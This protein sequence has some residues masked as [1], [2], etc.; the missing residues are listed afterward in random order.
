MAEDMYF[1]DLPSLVEV[2][3]TPADGVG[4]GWIAVE[5]ETEE[6]N[7][8]GLAAGS[9]SGAPMLALNLNLHGTYTLY[10]ALSTQTALKVWIEGE[11]GYREFVTE[12]GGNALQECQLHVVTLNGER[13]CIEPKNDCLPKPAFLGYIRAVPAA[14]P[15]PSARNMV[16]TN[17]GWS[18]VALDGIHEARDVWR[19][20]TPLRDSDFRLMLWGPAGAD[21]TGCHRTKVG[22]IAPRDT[23][24][25]FRVCDY[26]HAENLQAF[27]KTG[28][29][30]LAEAVAAARANEV[31][32]H[33]YIRPE[34]FFAPFPFNVFASQ[35]MLDHPEL[36]CRDE[37]DDEIMRLSYGYPEVQEHMLAYF[38]ELLEYRPDG[39]CFAFNRGL[40]MLICEA[41]VLAEFERLHGRAARLPEEADSDEMIAA[42]TS[43]LTQFLERVR[44][45]LAQRG[46]AFSCIVL[47]DE[48]HNRL[49]GLDLEALVERGVFESIMV[50]SGGMHAASGTGELTPYWRRLRDSGKVKIYPNGWNGTYDYA[51]QARYLKEN[52]FDQGFA[53]GFFW[54]TENFTT[55]PWNWLPLRRGGSP[56]HLQAL[57]NGS[58]ATPHITPFTRIQG[59]KLG[60]YNPTRSY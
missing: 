34:A 21:F 40:P 32:I 52:I 46:L 53:G 13:L 43:L 51:E 56:D 27:L 17:D 4:E 47:P 45:M 5:Y 1:M 16:A 10:L 15:P 24:H 39:L 59:V 6:R 58:I 38:A 26:V 33:F 19:F 9:R 48:E 54:D 37:F 42:R 20:F 31:E 30:I 44:A 14:A 23:K 7:G 11:R 2:G 28:G 8:R 36:R 50:Q 55:N 12:H 29:D 25:A 41:P 22:T 35:F 57:L 3:F 60:R 49:Y 18:W